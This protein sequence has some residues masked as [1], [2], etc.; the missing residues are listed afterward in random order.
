MFDPFRSSRPEASIDALA[1][2]RMLSAELLKMD[3]LLPALRFSVVL[4]RM[5]AVV[6]SRTS[7]P[8][9]IVTAHA[10]L[11][12]EPIADDLV[13]QDI[14]DLQKKLAELDREEHRLLDAYQAGLIP[15]DQLGRRQELLRQRR[16]LCVLPCIIQPAK[17]LIVSFC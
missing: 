9:L 2:A 8:A 5:S 10:R 7:D 1:P 13:A 17:D 3:V 15:L 16:A 14:R 12:T 4:L 11:Q 6:L